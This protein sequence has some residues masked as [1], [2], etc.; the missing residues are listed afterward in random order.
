MRAV[1]R[2]YLEQSSL[3]RWVSFNPSVDAAKASGRPRLLTSD[4]WGYVNTGFNANEFENLPKAAKGEAEK[5][6]HRSCARIFDHSFVT[7]SAVD[8]R[9]PAVHERYDTSPCCEPCDIAHSNLSGESLA[10][11]SDACSVLSLFG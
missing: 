5:T 10:C 7:E 11:P 2:E 1:K 8:G 4:D 3:F 6:K 9:A